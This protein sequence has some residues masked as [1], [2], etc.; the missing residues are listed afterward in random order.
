MTNLCK[1]A[2]FLFCG[3]ALLAP[4]AFGQSAQQTPPPAQQPPAA[5][6]ATRDNVPV[7]EATPLPPRF[8]AGFRVE[9]LPGRQFSTPDATSSSTNPIL[10]NAYFGTAVGSK[11]TFG[12]TAE[13]RLTRHLSVSGDFFY[14]QAEFVQL[15]QV[16]SGLPDPNSSYD[17]RPVTS[18]NEDTRAEYMDVPVVARYY[19]PAESA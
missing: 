5:P 7:T 2:R 12:V 6:A 10:S 16:K 4:W 1:Q 18:I 19:A 13:Y 3:F 15:T 9:Y 8:S 11:L 14:H 17:N